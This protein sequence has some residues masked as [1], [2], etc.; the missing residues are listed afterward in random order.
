M[1][2]DYP[3]LLIDMAAERKQKEHMPNMS[4]SILC[5]EVEVTHRFYDKL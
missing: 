2:Y 1:I 5:T 4:T 3:V